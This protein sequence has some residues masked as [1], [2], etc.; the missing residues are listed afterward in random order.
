MSNSTPTLMKIK[1]VSY[2]IGLSKA[3]AKGDP[4]VIQKWQDSIDDLT[5]QINSKDTD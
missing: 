3:I 4:D 5:D 2:N 1:L